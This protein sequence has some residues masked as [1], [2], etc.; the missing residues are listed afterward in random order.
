MKLEL[1]I[2]TDYMPGWGIWEGIRELVQNGRDAEVEQDALLTVRHRKESDILVIENEG[3]TLP[4][5]A[6][7]LGHTSKIGRPGALA[8]K[9]SL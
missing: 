8:L 9:A 5:E 4:H 2:K 6:L 1:T 7:L 3:C